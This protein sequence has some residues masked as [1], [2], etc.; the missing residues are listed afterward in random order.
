MRVFVLKPIASVCICLLAY[1]AHGAL[2]LTSTNTVDVGAIYNYSKSDHTFEIVNK[3]NEDILIK[4]L[5]STCPCIFGTKDKDVI[6][7]GETY[8]LKL[9]FNP[10]SVHG[11]FA[12]GVWLITNDPVNP[13]I[14]F[15]VTGE[16]LPLFTG[17]PTEPIVLQSENEGGAFTNK[18]TLKGADPKYTLGEPKFNLPNVPTMINKETDKNDPAT[19]RL[20]V[21]I[22]PPERIRMRCYLAIPVNG[23]E[24]IDDLKIDYQ[25]CIGMQLKASPTRLV[26]IDPAQPLTKRFYI[27]TYGDDTDA[28]LLTY[29][30]VMEGVTL[31]KEVFERTGIASSRVMP[32]KPNTSAIRRS[33]SNRITCTVSITAEALKKL[34]DKPEPAITLMYPGHKAVQMPLALMRQ[35]PAPAAA[36]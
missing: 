25:F 16:V 29:E 2:E 31:E 4:D 26:V 11:K 18:F 20:T 5:V 32:P 7:P 3:G 28:D 9:H 30:P 27:N 33:T 36:N 35:E 22:K 19:T 1:C 15:K 14:L 6:K 21:T 10:R 24:K 23:P 34:L 17:V 13:K 8:S 12:R